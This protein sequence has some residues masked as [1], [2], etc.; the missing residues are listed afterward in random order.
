MS[1]R[2][3]NSTLAKVVSGFTGVLMSVMML[4]GL[5][6]APAQ[7]QSISDLTAQIASLLATITGLQAQLST[8]TGGSTTSTGY[9]FAVNLKQGMTGT[10]VMNLQKV[11]NMSADTQV[12]TVPGAPGHPG[13]ETS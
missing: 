11:L 5:A 8:L 6:V 9:T 12:S 7:A 13:H 4:G 3:R 10:D 2:F 1:K